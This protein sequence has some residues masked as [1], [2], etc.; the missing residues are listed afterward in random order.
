LLDFTSHPSLSSFPW[1][2]VYVGLARAEKTVATFN[3]EE[4]YTH[5][6]QNVGYDMLPT[7]KRWYLA[8]KHGYPLMGFNVN[9]TEAIQLPVPWF[10]TGDAALWKPST[11]NAKHFASLLRWIDDC[12]IFSQVGRILFFLTLQGHCSPSHVDYANNGRSKPADAVNDILWITPPDNAKHFMVNGW[13]A[14]WACGFDPLSPHATLAS[15]KV[16]WSLRIDGRYS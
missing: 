5:G 2:D 1:E 13:Q 9:V 6:L 8:A 10:K 3:V 4:I 7:E 14:P 11:R 16:Q 15:D 12:R